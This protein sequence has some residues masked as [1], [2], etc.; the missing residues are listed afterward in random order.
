MREWE[1]GAVSPKRELQAAT[2][3]TCSFCLL[4]LNF[5]NILKITK[6]FQREEPGRRP[7]S[8]EDFDY[9]SKFQ[10]FLEIL[11]S[12][13]NVLRLARF[14]KPREFQKPRGISQQ[15]SLKGFITI[16]IPG[17]MWN[18]SAKSLKVFMVSKKPEVFISFQ[19]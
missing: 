3:F 16:E 19:K 15:E 7:K 9:A 4:I 10:Y 11:E 17:T 8:P 6:R 1:R 12:S 2:S 5:Q 14:Q 18:I 13:S